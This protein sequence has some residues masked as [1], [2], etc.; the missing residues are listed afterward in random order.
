MAWANIVGRGRRWLSNQALHLTVRYAGAQG[1]GAR[2][3]KIAIGTAII[4]GSVGGQ[5]VFALVSAL[6]FQT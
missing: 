1:E 3:Q 4:A 6:F 2:L 5:L